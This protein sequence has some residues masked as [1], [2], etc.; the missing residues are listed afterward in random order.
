MKSQEN[1]EFYLAA[2]ANAQNDFRGTGGGWEKW[3]L[4][5]CVA[6]LVGAAGWRILA[7]RK[8]PK[9]EPEKDF[10]PAPPPSFWES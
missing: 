8:Q 10:K 3:L 6:L 5:G 9:A 2:F 7:L 1:D 4:F